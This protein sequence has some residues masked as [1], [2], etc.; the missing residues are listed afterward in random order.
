[1]NTEKY[2]NK[3]M[4]IAK[5]GYYYTILCIIFYVISFGI[6]APWQ[7][8][9]ITLFLAMPTMMYFAITFYADMILLR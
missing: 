2:K 9:Y 8:D 3:A 1:M 7:N 5:Y 6:N 4:M